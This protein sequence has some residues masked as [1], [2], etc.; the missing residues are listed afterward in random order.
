MQMISNFSSMYNLACGLARGFR[1]ACGFSFLQRHFK[2]PFHFQV[3]FH[4][5]ILRPLAEWSGKKRNPQDWIRKK[6]IRIQHS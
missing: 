3:L 2:N 4:T 6:Y 5:L 1:L